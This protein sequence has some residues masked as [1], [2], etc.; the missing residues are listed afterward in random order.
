L[1]PSGALGGVFYALTSGGVFGGVMREYLLGAEW[2][3]SPDSVRM[4]LAMVFAAVYLLRSLPAEGAGG[5]NPLSPCYSLLG[6]LSGGACLNQHHA[7]GNDVAVCW[8]AGLAA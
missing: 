1:V 4:A 5:F 3:S 2:F 8:E 6:F 7:Y